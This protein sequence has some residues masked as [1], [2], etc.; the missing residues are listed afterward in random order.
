MRSEAPA[1]LPVF[2]SQHQAELLAQLL[3]RPGAELTLT[4]LS[5]RLDVPL[6]TLHREVQRLVAAELLRTRSVGRARLLSANPSHRATAPLTR[7]LE[8]SFGPA[9]VLAEEFDVPGTQIVVAFGS[10]AARHQGAAG[11][12]PRDLDVLVVG[13]VTRAVLYDAADRS[14]SR[15]GTEVNPVLRSP[16]QWAQGSDAL[17]DQVRR[18]PHVVLVD[19]RPD[20]NHTTGEP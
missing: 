13:D 15:L 5:R 10:W 12:A 1:L 17:V 18:S 20:P 8:L 19:H 11:P 6:T 7:L 16:A 9:V 2:R 14:Q 3:L 4:E